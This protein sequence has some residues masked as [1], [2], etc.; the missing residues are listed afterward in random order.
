MSTVVMRR[1]D[2]LMTT[3]A[4]FLIEARALQQAGFRAIEIATMV[5]HTWHCDHA[6]TSIEVVKGRRGTLQMI[7]PSGDRLCWSG[8]RWR[9]EPPPSAV[10]TAG[11]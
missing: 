3:L 10:P 4:D 7:F 9:L 6:E 2:I 1:G 11:V 8:K 5:Q